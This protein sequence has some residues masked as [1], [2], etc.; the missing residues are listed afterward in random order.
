M[1]VYPQFLQHIQDQGLYVNG[2]NYE[3]MYNIMIN[4]LTNQDNF[5]PASCFIYS[6]EKMNELYDYL[7]DLLHSTNEYNEPI[8][9]NQTNQTNQNEYESD[10]ETDIDSIY[11]DSEVDQIE[12][13]SQS[14][15]Q[16]QTHQP[17]HNAQMLNSYLSGIVQNTNNINYYTNIIYTNTNPSNNYITYL[18]NINNQ[19]IN[20]LINSNSN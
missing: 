12:P 18:N 16:T 6:Y 3:E 17:S 8:Q 9:T 2:Y 11:S 19:N 4:N 10:A 20:N 13:Q 14:Q 1:S 7:D 15:G 5:I